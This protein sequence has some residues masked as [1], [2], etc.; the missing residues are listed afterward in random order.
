M[1]STTS[2]CRAQEK[3][4]ERSFPRD[5]LYEAERHMWV[6]RQPDGLVRVGIDVL[7]LE[8]VGDLAYVSLC[9]IGAVAA[10]GTPIGALEAAKMTGDVLAP[11]SGRVVARNDAAMADPR[12]V[13]DDPYARGWLVCIE[14]S[15][16]RGE[17]RLLL[18]Q[19][20]LD[21]WIAREIDRY[22]REG[23]ID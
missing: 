1:A 22:R 14:P 9:E 8:S 2:A 16:W 12:I 11:I 21:A 23:W 7:G 15:D 5:R 13:N 4:D 6:L 18:G 3:I 20:A 10:R 17:S 19:A